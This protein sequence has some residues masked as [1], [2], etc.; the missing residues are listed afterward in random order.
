MTATPS[1]EIPAPRASLVGS[2]TR[3]ASIV[4]GEKSGTSGG[5]FEEKSGIVKEDSPPPTAG[6]DMLATVAETDSVKPLKAS[7]TAVRYSLLSPFAVSSVLIVLIE[8]A[9][10]WSSLL[11]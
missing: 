5:G 3:V 8:A 1:A 11:Q 2:E 4:N 7:D 10:D 9:S 6:S